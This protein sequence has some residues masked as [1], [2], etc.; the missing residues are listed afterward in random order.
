MHL[1]LWM[2]LSDSD[3]ALV[4]AAMLNTGDVR[5]QGSEARLLWRAVQLA[6]QS[7]VDDEVSVLVETTY[8]RTFT[9]VLPA[10][11]D[12][13]G[14]TAVDITGDNI[15]LWTPT[16][17]TFD[18]NEATTVEVNGLN[19]ITCRTPAGTASETPVDVVLSYD[20]GDDVVGTGAF[21]YT[22]VGP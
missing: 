14:N 12:E 2:D 20:Y 15:G 18:G 16:S 21:T 13:A 6:V 22:A 4:R 1:G 7:A 9:E 8:A 19:T 3:L 10:D 17:V 5:E 11:G